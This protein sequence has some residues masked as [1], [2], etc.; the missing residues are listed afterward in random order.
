MLRA[1]LLCLTLAAPALAQDREVDVELFLAVD[2][3][4]SMNPD[5]LEIQ[6]RGYAMALQSDEVI[7]A[8]L[9][10]MIGTVAITYV[11][12]AGS[13]SQRT[14]VPWTLIDSAEDAHAFAGQITANYNASMR[15][16][17]ISQALRHAADAFEGNGFSGLRR[18]IDIS[19]DGPNNQGG[20]VTA[21]RDSVLDR[22]ITINGLPLMTEDPL[23]ASWGIPDLDIYYIRCVIGGPGAFILPVTHWDQF[24][25]AVQ[26]KLILEI[27]GD[28]PARLHRAQ[29]R[30]LPPYDC[31]VGEKIWERN[32]RYLDWP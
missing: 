19:G 6:R 1:I 17:S 30:S 7:A 3:S 28:L 11:E 32:R 22:G 20:L 13:H 10:G 18:V 31:E 23:T 2:V 9:N 5:E 25:E 12:W 16:T 14:V 21:A 29:S 15:R 4:R 8:I 26:R 27:A 24:A